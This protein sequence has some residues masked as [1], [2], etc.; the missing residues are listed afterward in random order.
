MPLEF[1]SDRPRNSVKI[2]RTGE[3]N[4]SA[5]SVDGRNLIPFTNAKYLQDGSVIST[6][7]RVDIAGNPLPPS[8]NQTTTSVV[9]ASG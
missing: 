7:A 5:T 4:T 9:K 3:E 1:K 6:T 8:G 2:Y